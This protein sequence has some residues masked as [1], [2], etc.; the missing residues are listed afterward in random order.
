MNGNEKKPEG[1]GGYIFISHSHEDIKKVREIRN[2]LESRE[3]EPILF[4][5]RCMKDG[6]EEEKAELW[7]LIRREIDE[8]DWFLYLD[9]DNARQSNWVQQETEYARKAK[10]GYIIQLDLSQEIEKIQAKI[11]KL[12]RA[13]RVYISYARQDEELFLKFRKE[14]ERQDFQVLSTFDVKPVGHF[15]DQIAEMIRSVCD[16]GCFIPLLTEKSIRSRY[17]TDEIRYAKTIG[18]SFV[19]PISTTTDIRLQNPDG[20]QSAILQR[21]LTDIQWQVVRSDEDI[22]KIVEI[23]RRSLIHR[24]ME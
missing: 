9:S 2:Y 16:D 14:F 21:L 1:L 22:P 20:E 12:S 3:I 15:P 24:I 18:G 10:D 6:T 11:E 8:R 4:Y 13:M 19:F 7:N 5:L 23:I 17:V